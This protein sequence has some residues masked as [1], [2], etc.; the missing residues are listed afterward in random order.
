MIQIYAYTCLLSALSIVEMKPLYINRR[1][2]ESVT[3]KCSDWDAWT[4]VKENVKYFCYSPCSEDHHIIGKAA[5]GEI[6]Y[7]NRIMLQNKEKSLFVTFTNLQKSDSKTYVCVF[8]KSGYESFIKVILNVT[9]AHSPSPKTTPKT[10][11]V[12]STLSFAVT[13][14]STMSS[15]F[16][17]IIT[18]MSN[19]TLNTT[20]ASATPGSDSDVPYL[21]IGVI[22]IITVLMVLLKLM[23]KMMKQQLSKT[24]KSTH[25]LQI[26]VFSSKASTRL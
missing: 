17:D 24:H 6:I 5:Y 4:D 22:G 2:G 13:Y 16:S 15:N 11:I 26:C 3:I 1:V 7:E 8:E 19:T 9:E 21:V 23:S 10:V 20:T 25:T 12:G 18:E 14:S